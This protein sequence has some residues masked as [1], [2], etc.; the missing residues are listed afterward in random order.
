MGA[1]DPVRVCIPLP[2]LFQDALCR[3]WG[4][5]SLWDLSVAGETG[6]E[7]RDRLAA[8]AAIC[9]QCPCR[10]ACARVAQADSLAT[11][12]WGGLMF[13][14]TGQGVSEIIV[15]TTSNCLETG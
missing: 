4:D 15:E 9:S 12:V 10:E 5:P 1:H 7:R 13:H 14:A 2:P 3:E 8:A 6:I 11:G